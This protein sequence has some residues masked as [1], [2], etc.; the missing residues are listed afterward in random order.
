MMNLR[1]EPEALAKPVT[2]KERCCRRPA[3]PEIDP[4]TERAA[5]AFLRHLGGRYPVRE[6]ILYGSRARRTHSPD[7]DADI[8]VVL[9]GVGGNRWEMTRELSGI[10]FDVLVETGIR[11]QALPLWEN[12]LLGPEQFSNPALIANIQRVGVRL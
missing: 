1:Q 5:R 12:D 4:D 11:V 9:E 7:S 8:S 2:D 10:A 6:A 3:R